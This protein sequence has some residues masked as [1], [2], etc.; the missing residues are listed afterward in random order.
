MKAW[1]LKLWHRYGLAL[2]AHRRWCELNA[3]KHERSRVLPCC[4]APPPG[5][6][7]AGK[8]ANKSAE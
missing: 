8:R 6:G 7:Q 3:Q 1:F 5:V 4:S 2:Q